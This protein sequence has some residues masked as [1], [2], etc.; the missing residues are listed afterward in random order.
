MAKVRNDGEDD[1]PAPGIPIKKARGG[2][3]DVEPDMDAPGIPKRIV[4]NKNHGHS[5]MPSK[6]KHGHKPMPE[7]KKHG[8]KPMKM[9]GA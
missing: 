5:E 6:M 1:M 9:K 7:H 4:L 8:H 3:I 2:M